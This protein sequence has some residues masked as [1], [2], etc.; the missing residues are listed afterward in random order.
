MI[1]AIGAISKFLSGIV[2]AFIILLAILLAGVKLFGYTP[3]TVLSASM[4]PNYHVGSM[5]YVTDVDPSDL[6]VGDPITY[7]ISNGIVVT[8]RIVEVLDENTSEISFRTKGD[9]NKDEDGS[10]V[11]ASAIIGKPRFSIPYLGYVSDFVKRPVGLFT[12]FGTCVMLLVISSLIELLLKQGK[13]KRF[14]K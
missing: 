12:L 2:I 4:E 13:S 8:H 5:I 11:S 1:R 10:S 7:R 9:A 3:Y 6:K 14:G